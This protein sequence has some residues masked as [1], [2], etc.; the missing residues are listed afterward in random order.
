MLCSQGRYRR[1]F[2]GESVMITCRSPT[3]SMGTVRMLC[4]SWMSS[5]SLRLQQSA[6]VE[7]E[8]LSAGLQRRSA[9][10]P[11]CPLPPKP[12][13][14]S[15]SHREWIRIVDRFCDGQQSACLI[16]AVI[17]DIRVQTTDFRRLLWSQ[18]IRLIKS[19]TEIALN[20]PS[21]DSTG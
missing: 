12:H 3:R 9:S 6:G 8:P 15:V 7:R 17:C 4:G 2:P 21:I 19:K 11:G 18:L 1:V 5:C 16:Q 20:Q 13:R 10:F 14:S